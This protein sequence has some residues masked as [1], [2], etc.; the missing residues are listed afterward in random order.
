[1]LSVKL[2]ILKV[3]GAFTSCACVFV[4]VFVYVVVVAS[5]PCRSP[6]GGLEISVL[7]CCGHRG[8]SVVCDNQGSGFLHN[9]FAISSSFQ[10]EMLSFLSLR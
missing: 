5:S 4:C 6:P 3:V 7:N 1:M 9:C 10:Y 8:K 2:V